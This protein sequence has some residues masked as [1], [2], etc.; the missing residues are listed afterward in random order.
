M[1]WNKDF[2][3]KVILNFETG[4]V[5]QI[6]ENIEERGGESMHDRLAY[7]CYYA[8]DKQNRICPLIKNEQGTSF[9]T[10]LPKL[11]C[12]EIVQKR[13]THHEKR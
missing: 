7:T 5:T 6:K 13:C 8:I 4:G 12:H 3:Y 9:A 10:L 11:L 1:R 2:D